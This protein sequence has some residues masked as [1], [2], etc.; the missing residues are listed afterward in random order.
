MSATTVRVAKPPSTQKSSTNGYHAAP[1]MADWL[2]D[3]AAAMAR[4]IGPYTTQTAEKYLEEY[5]VELYNGWLVWQEMTNARE[6]TVVGTIQDMFS[7][8][9]RNTGFG[10]VLPD[11]LECHLNDST[12]IKP[13]ASLISWQRLHDYVQLYGPND[14]PTL[15]RCPKLVVEVRSSSNTRRGEAVKRAQ[16]FAHGTQIVW[17]VDE[18]KE[19][20]YVYRADVPNQPQRYGIDD[21]IDCE[22]ILRGWQRRVADI[23]SREL[24]A[25]AVIGEVADELRDEGRKEGRE[26]G[27]EQ[28][29][30]EIVL[31]MLQEGMDIAMIARLTG[32][33]HEQI[34]ALQAF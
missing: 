12:D 32:L 21:I 9:A 19:V 28:R 17:D 20:I 11:Q 6:R 3:P 16:Y 22:P 13:D 7:I 5:P 26:E 8:S 1:E 24:S 4:E 15:M 2:H 23:F 25:E 33:T 30:K 18:E 29:N 14:R 34:A 27:M 31:A 10:Q